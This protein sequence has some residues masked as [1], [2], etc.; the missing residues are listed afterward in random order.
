MKQQLVTVHELQVYELLI[1]VLGSINNLHGEDLLNKLFSFENPLRETR[2]DKLNLLKETSRLFN[3][4]KTRCLLKE[5]LENANN[6][7]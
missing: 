3:L 1:F 2:R 7:N 6:E 5:G 4:L